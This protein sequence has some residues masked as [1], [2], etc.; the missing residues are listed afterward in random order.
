M[1]LI[2][3]PKKATAQFDQDWSTSL[4]EITVFESDDDDERGRSAYTISSSL[5]Q[6]KRDSS[7]HKGLHKLSNFMGYLL[8]TFKKASM[9][10][11]MTY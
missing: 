11:N 5:G 1:Q 3:H 2:Q 4:R 10:E 7:Y 6:L 9:R 8:S